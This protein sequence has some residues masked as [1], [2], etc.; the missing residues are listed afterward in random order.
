MSQNK[1]Q[2]ETTPYEFL[3]VNDQDLIDGDFES[4]VDEFTKYFHQDSWEDIRNNIVKMYVLKLEGK[5]MGYVTL[6]NAHI[7][8]D[9][10]KE[11]K[12]KE[13]NGPVP[14]LLISHLAV[15]KDEQRRHVGQT[16]LKEVFASVVPKITPLA[17]YRY[18]ML[19][20]RADQGVRDFYADA[21]FDY[22]P[23][24]VDQ[25]VTDEKTGKVF[26][27]TRDACLYDLLKK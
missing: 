20:P 22:Y 19:N 9:A 26:D 10:T 24:F 15:A 14:A 17:G 13:I 11:I 18:V 4:S 27:K 25:R 16:M 2:F 12:T 7:R 23:R 21:G 5:I 8:H 1:I 3:L 6:A